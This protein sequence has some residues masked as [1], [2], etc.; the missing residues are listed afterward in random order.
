MTEAST[1]RL[2]LPALIQKMQNEGIP[3]IA[4][5]TFS[6]Y[7]E[8]VVSGESGMIWDAEIRPLDPSDIQDHK[9]LSDFAPAGK[10]AFSRAVRIVLNGG[11]GTSMGL[12][13]T[14]SLLRVKEGLS[15]LEIIFKQAA[16]QG[17]RLALMNSF[18]TDR[19]TREAIRWMQTPVQPLIFLQHRFPKILKET[20]APASWPKNPELEWNPPGHG[21]VYTALFSSGTL[22]QLLNEGIEFAFISNSDNL[23]AVM[24]ASLLGY[25][26]HKA[27]PFMMEVA[28]RTPTDIKGGHL[29]VRRRD[30]RFILREAAQ[31]PEEERAAFQDIHRYRFFNTNNIW[32]NLRFLKGVLEHD[33]VFP[34]P[35]ILNEKPLDSRDETSPKVYQIESAMG[36]AIS[37]FDGSTAV[38]VPKTR[39]IPVKK[40]QDLLLVRSDRYLLTAEGRLIPNSECGT[41]FLYVSLD[42]RFYSKIEDFESRFAQGV[43]SLCECNALTIRGDVRFERDVKVVGDVVIENRGTGQGVVKAGSVVDRDLFF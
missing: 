3:E 20:L 24:D 35:L 7:Y 22:D 18:N 30:N 39:M 34:L 25:F 42:P 29:A 12:S 4:V 41:A 32:V 23:G 16:H 28:Q 6:R 11:L 8:R 14:K 10:E 40:C 9:T 38:C 13:S 15:F 43:P 31:C 19:E 1:R 21:N 37:L 36:A 33:S 2:Y 17:V 5:D 27:F 26:A